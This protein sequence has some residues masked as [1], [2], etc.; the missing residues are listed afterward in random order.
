VKKHPQ[1]AQFSKLVRY[2]QKNGYK[3]STTFVQPYDK[4]ERGYWYAKIEGNSIFGGF[5]EPN[6]ADCY[7]YIKGRIAFDH[8]KCFDKWSKCPYSLELPQ[9]PKEFEYIIE[10]MKYLRTKEGFEK[11]I[12]SSCG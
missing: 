11:L 8:K 10:Q 4:R 2:I 1:P 12:V 5:C 9:T 3:I 7:W 6:H